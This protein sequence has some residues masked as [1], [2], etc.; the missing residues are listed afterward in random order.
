MQ[1]LLVAVTLK[2]ITMKNLIIIILSLS[3]FSCNKS[4]EET[5]L[6]K[7]VDMKVVEINFWKDFNDS[8]YVS[9]RYELV[10]NNTQ[11]YGIRNIEKNIFLNEGIEIGSEGFFVREND[12][13][14]HYIYYNLNE[15][16][17]W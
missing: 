9:L 15:D 6:P 8:D 11:I 14:N 13:S 4:T 1:Y 2:L 7:I 12:N 17:G 3:L 16:Y 10:N 5:G